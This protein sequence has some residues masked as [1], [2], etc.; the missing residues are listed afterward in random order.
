MSLKS[1]LPPY[2]T[3]ALFRLRALA[4][5]DVALQ[6]IFHIASG[7]LLGCEALLRNPRAVGCETIGEVVD[8]SFRLGES[9]AL[10][11]ILLEKALAKRSIQPELGGSL[12]FFNLDGR[13]L[14][15]VAPA[16][17]ALEAALA[18][19]GASPADVCLELSEQNQAIC[20]PRH[21]AGIAALKRAGFRIAMDDFG[22]GF[23][24]LRMLYE[25]APDY[26]KIDRFFVENLNRDDKKKVFIRA[27]TDMAHR[28]GATVVAE[29][30]ETAA[31]H[32]FARDMGCDL[33][34][35]YFCGR[36]TLDPAGIMP[37]SQEIVNNPDRRVRQKGMPPVQ[38]ALV[39]L[40]TINPG[41]KFDDLFDLFERHR[42]QTLIPVID[43][44]GLVLGV[45]FEADVKPIMYS[46]F[47]RD[48]VRN[49]SYPATVRSCMRSMLTV[50]IATSAEGFLKY[51]FE[52]ICDG[53]LITRDGRYA[54]Y[55]PPASI[56]A[57]THSVQLDETR[58][59]NPLTGLPGNGPIR[60]YITE[61]ESNPDEARSYAY[62]DFDNFKPFNDTYGFRQGDRAI[63]L[64]SEIMKRHLSNVFIGHVGGDDF[65][66]GATG[67]AA[68]QFANSIEL[69]IRKFRD[70]VAAF[71]SADDRARG[72]IAGTARDGAPAV[73]PLMTCSAAILERPAGTLGET[74]DALAE[75]LAQ[76]KKSAKS[77]PGLLVRA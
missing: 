59:Q 38:G 2:A 42:N 32:H 9:S 44:R 41:A 43:R 39:K 67:L 45:V 1:H 40:A 18:S 52:D 47:G 16:V 56:F 50:D 37:I 8:L 17:A 71:Y 12:L 55:L 58:N 65:F 63:L 21:A 70:G 19:N 29:G 20:D 75:R 74:A 62:L 61:A 14:L 35:G 73:F 25:T 23:S 3:P 5:V 26:I 76:I 34:Q 49:P 54:G 15:D 33:V 27:L 57:M 48:L 64:M 30:V 7:R 24:G 10:D 6:P 66:A 60:N 51:D 4:G 28:L 72:H 53:V 77:A 46:E 11:R 31:E 13:A 69:A 68:D 22:C 36:P